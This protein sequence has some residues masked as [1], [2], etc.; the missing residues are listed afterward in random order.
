M[1]NRIIL[2]TCQIL[3]LGQAVWWGPCIHLGLEHLARSSLDLVGENIVDIQPHY[4]EY[5]SLKLAL[6]NLKL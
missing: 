3:L 6:K 5:W 2:M 4:K 1:W